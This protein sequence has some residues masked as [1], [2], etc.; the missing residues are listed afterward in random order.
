MSPRQETA[1]ETINALTYG[2]V[3]NKKVNS[4]EVIHDKQNL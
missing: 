3:N 4:H 1:K 2:S